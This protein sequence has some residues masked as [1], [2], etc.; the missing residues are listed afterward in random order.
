MVALAA[1]ATGLA[2]LATALPSKTAGRE[3][4]Q[5]AAVRQAPLASTASRASLT[6]AHDVLTLST[7][8]PDASLDIGVDS[9]PWL[10]SAGL[11]FRADGK[12]WST[13]AGGGHPSAAQSPERENH[14]DV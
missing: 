4:H 14:G 9:A 8:G 1:F 5:R 10:H 11:F 7:P 2:A 12:A 3:R 13:G 6:R